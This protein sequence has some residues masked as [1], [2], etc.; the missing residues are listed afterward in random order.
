[1]DEDG[2]LPGEALTGLLLLV[3]ARACSVA[4]ERD[5]PPGEW[6]AE[7]AQQDE[8]YFGEVPPHGECSKD[9]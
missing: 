5:L 9:V 3:A 1:M 2:A 7:G 8:V 6:W 4:D